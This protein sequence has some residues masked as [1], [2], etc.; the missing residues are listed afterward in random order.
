MKKEIVKGHLIFDHDGTLAYSHQGKMQFFPG[1]VDYLR[2]LHLDNFKLY[3]WTARPRQST[4]QSLKNNNALGFFQELS[5]ADDLFCK[6]D[7]RALEAMLGINVDKQK[8][9]HIGDSFG[10]FEGAD[11]FGID[12]IFAGWYSSL[13][14]ELEEKKV[15]CASQLDE[16]KQLIE[17][18]F[19]RKEDHV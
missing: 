13:P 14:S 6:P 17:Q 11:R 10:D 19:I 12:F 7:Y 8:A 4:L 1:M 5:C 15:K 18:K 9:L 2:Q 16:L 3:V